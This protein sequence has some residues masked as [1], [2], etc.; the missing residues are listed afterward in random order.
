MSHKNLETKSGQLTT[1]PSYFNGTLLSKN[2]LEVRVTA[3]ISY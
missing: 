1:N 2:Y 3:V